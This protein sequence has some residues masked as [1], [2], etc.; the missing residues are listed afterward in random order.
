MFNLIERIIL[1]I[2]LFCTILLSYR[3]IKLLIRIIQ[4]GQGNVPRSLTIKRLLDVILVKLIALQPTWKIRLVP[5]LFH[6][7]VVWGFLYYLLINVS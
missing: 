3:E 6:A 2:T 7:F 4:R 1:T 5:S